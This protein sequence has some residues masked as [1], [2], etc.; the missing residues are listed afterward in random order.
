MTAVALLFTAAITPFEVAF[1]GEAESP[2]DWLWILN[3]L[4]DIVFL[5][6]IFLNF[7]V[8]RQELN[9]R[10]FGT[11]TWSPDMSPCLVPVDRSCTRSDTTGAPAP[12]GTPPCLTLP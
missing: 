12:F 2:S 11:A 1:L 6:D 5:G 8:C 9:R 7:F 10:P 3:R 4:V